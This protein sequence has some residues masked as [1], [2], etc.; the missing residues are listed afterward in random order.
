MTMVYFVNPYANN[1][2]NEKYT[3]GGQT[4]DKT[5]SLSAFGWYGA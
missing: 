1:F 3:A 5:N 2:S 4:T